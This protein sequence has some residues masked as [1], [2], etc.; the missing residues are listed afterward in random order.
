M[1]P[2]GIVFGLLVFVFGFLA[3]GTTICFTEP[4]VNEANA[5]ASSPAPTP[6]FNV[7]SLGLIAFRATPGG[8]A[9][10]NGGRW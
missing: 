3:I 6:A 1:R 10:T 2:R 8:I 7:T 5:Q 4:A 9:N